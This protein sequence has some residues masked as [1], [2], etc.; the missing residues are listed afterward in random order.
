MRESW[1]RVA[2]CTEKCTYWVT[3]E[4]GFYISA[5]IDECLEAGEE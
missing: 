3:R 4:Y 1:L 5:C 2:E